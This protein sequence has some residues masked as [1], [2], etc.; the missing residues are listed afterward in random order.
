MEDLVLDPQIRDWVV[1]PIVVMMLFITLLRHY[2]MSVVKST[3]EATLQQVADTYAP[4]NPHP[5]QLQH[6]NKHYPRHHL[7]STPH[8]SPLF[9][10]HTHPPHPIHTP[11][12]THPIHPHTLAYTH[13]HLLPTIQHI[14]V[15]CVFSPHTH[16][17]L[18][19]LSES[20]STQ[21][22]TTPPPL[23][24]LLSSTRYTHTHTH[25]T[26]TL[27]QSNTHSHK[28]T[29]T[30]SSLSQTHTQVNTTQH[31]NTT[32]QQ[33]NNTQSLDLITP[34]S[35]PPPGA[36]CGVSGSDCTADRVVQVYV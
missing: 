1:I 6:A 26:H 15:C 17:S 11:P 3:P 29:H 20:L 32:Q 5:L 25:V 35:P 28:H 24:Y 13:P 27:P 12:P 34:H 4:P 8:H 18:F 10:P 30:C 14:Q 21:L 31:N 23:F 9:T 36:E 33:H 19:S 22:P 16:T 7:S 2:V